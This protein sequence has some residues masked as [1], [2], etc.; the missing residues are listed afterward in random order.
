MK[1]APVGTWGRALQAGAAAAR[2]VYT[3]ELAHRR[4]LYPIERRVP[5]FIDCAL[6]HG[7]VHQGIP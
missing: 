4:R 2:I 5:P 3:Q 6:G 1:R 7:L